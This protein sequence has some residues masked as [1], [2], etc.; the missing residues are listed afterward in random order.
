MT[1]TLDTQ[2]AAVLGAAF[3]RSGPPPSQLV[4]DVAGRRDKREDS[5]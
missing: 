2:V 4:G 5:R 1:F 3:E